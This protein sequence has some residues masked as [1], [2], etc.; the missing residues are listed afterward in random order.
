MQACRLSSDS[1][2]QSPRSHPSGS[3]GKSQG[4]EIDHPKGK[5]SA[6][7][8]AK[9][10]NKWQAGDSA[11]E[12]DGER[13]TSGACKCKAKPHEKFRSY[14]TDTGSDS[15]SDFELNDRHRSR[16]KSNARSKS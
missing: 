14:N 1:D 10:A 7:L 4:S 6:K 16:Y 11:A 9:N 8:H 15:E 2:G 3:D 13:P 12:S 5:V